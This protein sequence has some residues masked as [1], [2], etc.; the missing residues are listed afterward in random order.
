MLNKK[1]WYTKSVFAGAA[2]SWLG[3]IFVVI[4]ICVLL[5]LLGIRDYKSKTITVY[6]AVLGLVVALIVGYL[7]PIVI[8]ILVLS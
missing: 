3:G 5:L 4:G 2:A 6:D 1:G 8:M 7:L